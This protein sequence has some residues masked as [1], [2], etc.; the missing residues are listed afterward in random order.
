MNNDTNNTL[1]RMT[2]L[3]FYGFTTLSPRYLYGSRVPVLLAVVPDYT[4]DQWAACNKLRRIMRSAE[5]AFAQVQ[6]QLNIM[7]DAA[8]EAGD[9]AG[10]DALIGAQVTLAG[11]IEDSRSEPLRLGLVTSMAGARPD[12]RFVGTSLSGDVAQVPDQ[13]SPRVPRTATK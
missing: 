11:L 2:G 6:E 13:G 10:F 12:R 5:E 4:G 9:M 3:V 7:A 8:D 1:T